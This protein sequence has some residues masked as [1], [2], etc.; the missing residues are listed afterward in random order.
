M[1][2]TIFLY[3]GMVLKVLITYSRS[4]GRASV[5]SLFSVHNN[6]CAGWPEVGAGRASKHGGREASQGEVR[7]A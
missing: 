2:R 1:I 5:L 3:I 4:G 7:P 6:F